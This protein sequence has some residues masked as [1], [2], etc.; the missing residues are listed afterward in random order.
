M[1]FIRT[2]DLMSQQITNYKV[3]HVILQVWMHQKFFTVYQQK[4]G[5]SSSGTE[6]RMYSLASAQI[7]K[8][9]MKNKLG[10]TE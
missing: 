5:T 10:T 8:Q 4:N 7:K 2:R 6:C 9:L 1:L 3:D